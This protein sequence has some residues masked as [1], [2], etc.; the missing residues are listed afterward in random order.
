MS[1]VAVG[2]ASI[3]NIKLAEVVEVPG[4]TNTD[5]AVGSIIKA[6]YIELWLTSSSTAQG[7]AIVSFEKLPNYGVAMSFGNSTVLQDYGN[8]PNIY[9]IA[10]GLTPESKQVPVAL[11]RGWYKI[12]KGKQRFTL[13]DILYLNV[14]API[15]GASVCGV[16]IFKAYT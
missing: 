2:S 5:V 1:G 15:T 16:V 8:K 14:S 11:M 10:M 7:N 6:V 4:S 3:N 13:G 12:P 9:H